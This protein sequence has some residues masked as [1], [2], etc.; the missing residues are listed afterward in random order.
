MKHSPSPGDQFK[1]ALLDDY[2]ERNPG[3]SRSQ[4]VMRLKNGKPVF[5][6]IDHVMGS[7]A[8]KIPKKHE[9][10]LLD[11]EIQ[12]KDDERYQICKTSLESCKS[13]VGFLFTASF[14]QFGLPEKNDHMNT[15][16]RHERII[17]DR[18][19][20]KHH[21]RQEF[22]EMMH[23]TA[24]LV[25][26][27]VRS[28]MTVYFRSVLDQLKSQ[29]EILKL[30]LN[31][32]R[33]M[34]TNTKD[35]IKANVSKVKSNITPILAKALTRAYT[36]SKRVAGEVVPQPSKVTIEVLE[37]AIDKMNTVLDERR[38]KFDELVKIIAFLEKLVIQMEKGEEKEVQEA[39]EATSPKKKSGGMAFVTKLFSRK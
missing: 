31:L 22:L 15:L 11:K 17:V 23:G 10:E 39:E 20:T 24:A 2:L 19:H 5:D 35:Y 14:V 36:V 3:L 34:S 28:I 33:D 13:I 25:R 12:V 8:L 26:P 6:T 21:I 29:S 1:D 7:L 32:G 37:A 9:K 16:K 30:E 18:T 27:R 38:S 4:V